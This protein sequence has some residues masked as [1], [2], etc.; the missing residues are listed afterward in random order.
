MTAE[1]RRLVALAAALLPDRARRL[2]AR[3]PAPSLADEGA[4]LAALARRDRLAALAASLSGTAGPARAPASAAAERG[5]VAELLRRVARG[6]VPPGPAPA[7]V[8]LCRE[9]LLQ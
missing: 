2:L 1:D 5:A 8:R 7:L 4:R 6:E 3:A 9:R